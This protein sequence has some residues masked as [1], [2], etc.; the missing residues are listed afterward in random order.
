MP[1]IR[2][3]I[4]RILAQV[5]RPGSYVSSGDLALELP[6]LEV[7]GIGGIGLPVSA[8]QA[9]LLGNHCHVAP[10]G[11]GERTLVD[12]RVRDV[13]ELDPDEFVLANPAWPQL[14]DRATRKVSTELGL[15]ADA[16]DAHLY[17]LL[18]YEPGG[19]F[20][21]HQDGERLDGMVATLVLQLPCGHEGGELVVRHAG[22]ERVLDLGGPQSA[23]TLRYAAFY[24]DCEHEIRPLQSGFRL[25]LVYNLTLS[26]SHRDQAIEGAPAYGAQ[27][28]ALQ[29]IFDGWAQSEAGPDKLAIVLQ[30]EYTQQGLALQSLK[31][32]DRA[33]ANVLFDALGH[34]GSHAYLA[35]LT[36]WESGIGEEVWGGP[37]H[38]PSQRRRQYRWDEDELFDEA[39]DDETDDAY[40]DDDLD[41]DDYE[42]D[43]DDDALGGGLQ[44][45]SSQGDYRMIEVVDAGLSV[46]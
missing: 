33:R 13:L 44:D 8:A 25:C 43:V 34:T 40:A 9:K 28:E 10:Y 15:A 6:G 38:H 19:F 20:L 37:G 22:Q 17:K 1:D 16:L 5:D 7:P 35:L 30:H 42:A 45:P 11:K 26:I 18:L 41:E 4:A 21:S 14:V 29:T 2:Q 24:A 31:G 36:L 12:K 3:S 32:I 23:Y 27:T 46:E 39:E